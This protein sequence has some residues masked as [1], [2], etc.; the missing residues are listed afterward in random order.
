MMYKNLRFNIAIV[1]GALLVGGA[2]LGLSRSQVFVDDQAYMKGMIP[3]HSIAI[4]T[5]ERADIEE[6]G[7]ATS[8][9]AAEDRPV[10][11]FE[12]DS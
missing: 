7:P 9:E 8:Q 10:P 3:H 6:N 4:L 1:V 12:A 11:N 2:A 5:S